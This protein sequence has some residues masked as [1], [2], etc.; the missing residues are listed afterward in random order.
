MNRIVEKVKDIV[1]VRT[2]IG[3]NNFTDDPLRTLTGYH[4]TDVTA[5]LMSKWLTRAIRVGPGNGA[6][7]ALAGFRGVGKSHFLATFG[8]ILSH[9]EMR[10]R[11]S[12]DLVSSTAQSITRR[13][14]PVA[15]VRRGIESTLFL[16]LRKAVAPI[17]GCEPDALSDSLSDILMRAR[18]STGDDP[19]ILLIDTAFE[20][21][22][23]VSRDDGAV[24]SAIAETAKTLGIFVGI[25]LDDDI[26]G[27]DGANS[28]ISTTFGIDY[29]D[30]EHLYRIVDTHIFP[31]QNRM[32]P[33]LHGIYQY[34]RTAVPSFRWSEERFSALYPL[35]P[36]IMEIAPFVRLYMHDF[37]LLS[38]ASE[39]GSRILG[40]PANS[41]IAP[42]EVFDKVE[43]NLRNVDAL[44]EAFA[45]FDRINTE[46]ISKVPVV[47]RL[48]AKLILK[49]LFLFSLN[50]EGA[51]ASE[52]G[53]SMLIYDENEPETAVAYVESLIAS[54][55]AAFPNNIRA[56]ESESRGTRYSFILDGKDDLKRVL[57]DRAAKVPDDVITDILRR[58]IDERFPDSSF[59]DGQSHDG[60]PVSDCVISWRGGLR[61]GQ[62]AWIDS[63]KPLGFSRNGSLD[64]VAGICLRDGVSCDPSHPD[65]IPVVTWSPAKLTDE[66]ANTVR[67]FY[68]LQ[69]DADLRSEFL[70]HVAAAAQA[71]AFAVDKVF[72][73]AFLVDGVIS[74]EGFEYNFTEEAR[75][76]QSLSQI[77]TIMLESL[78]EGRFPM[79]PYFE[80]IIRT[81]DVTALVT[82]FYGGARPR[83]E[84]VQ[85]MAQ[86][87]CL[88]LGAASSVE[89]NYVPAD[90]DALR[91]QPLVR[92]LFDCINPT[93]GEVT[94][95]NSIFSKLGAAPYGLV[96]E[97]GYLLLSAMVSARL[98]DFVTSNGDR[99]SH[100]SLD[101]KV[102]WD[103]IVGVALPTESVYS[104]ERLLTW[105]TLITDRSGFGSLNKSED[106]LEILDA[107]GDWL[108]EWKGRRISARFDAVR[109]DLLNT[110]TWRLAAMSTKSFRVAAESIAAV[111]ENVLPLEGG[112][113]RIADAFSDSEIEYAR[114]R[115]DLDALEDFIAGVA[116]REQV[117]AWLSL[118]ELTGVKE[119][120]R[121]RSELYEMTAR[122]FHTPKA[123]SNI[124]LNNLWTKF[125]KIYAEFYVDRHDSAVVSPYLR[126]KLAE[127]MKTDLWWEFEN[128]S[129]IDGFDGSFRT[130][131]KRIIQKIRQLD[132]RRNTLNMIADVPTCGCPFSIGEIRAIEALPEDLWHVVTRGLSSYRATL[133]DLEP[134]LH[135]ALKSIVAHEKSDRIRQAYTDLTAYLG[136]EQELRRLS[137]AEI[138]LI[139][140]AF[141]TIDAAVPARPVKHGDTEPEFLVD[142]SELPDFSEAVDELNALLEAMPQ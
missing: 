54:F 38:F 79:H 141:R 52:I 90:A 51:T 53:A 76:A 121:M 107:L 10:S 65:G 126:E 55:A 125:K 88:P 32:Q 42:D 84:E 91:E 34:Y 35:H 137:G 118:C 98:L 123:S 33:V 138:R 111:L 19:L 87:Y 108:S 70:D 57:N 64:W 80:S 102:I 40:R 128:L 114:H 93:R 104:N 71:H 124:D 77:F 11:L 5:D 66:E 3:L 130:E 20:R 109:D 36:A 132:C 86:L 31:K 6:A 129:D 117:S 62:V 92:E 96:R 14:Y 119:I 139:R 120:D 113:Q 7:L 39:A 37:A 67:R 16:E 116:L 50:D 21:S 12:D 27:A 78:F 112:L 22:S 30:Q 23:R 85:R 28:A 106:R 99:I 95:L 81:K 13:S 110:R 2:H 69:T 103:D 105:V 142:A 45:A 133:H 101:L 8:T 24:L 61:K 127:I 83:I 44:N 97:A 60:V 26:S 68:V 89:S 18:E 49:G 131:S 1:D 115:S 136:K 82:D 74:I 63:E 17:I 100:R 29:L 140:R 48:Q 9:P 72:Q 134:Q 47:K 94:T 46:I 25:A 73:R 122:E 135:A 59:S 43:K 75:T 41:L 56:Q 4:F 15:F 58:V